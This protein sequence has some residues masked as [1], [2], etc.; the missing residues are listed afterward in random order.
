MAFRERFDRYVCEGDSIAVEIDGFRVTARIVRD[1]C[2]DSPDERQDGFWPSLNIGDPGFIG[3]GNNFRERLTKAQADAEAVMDAWRKDE[4]FYCGI[5]LAIERESVEL[6]S[7][8]ASIWGIEAND[9]GSENAYLTE[10]A[11][12][13]LPEALQA[14]HRALARLMASAPARVAQ[15]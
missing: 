6:E 14:G 5:V 7:H 12:E 3:P 10:V 11:C 4:W 9:P 13:L 15:A 1:D 2:P 8:A